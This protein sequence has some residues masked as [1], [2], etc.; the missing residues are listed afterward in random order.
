MRNIPRIVRKIGYCGS[1]LSGCRPVLQYNQ[2]R[3]DD[4][5]ISP[6]NIVSLAS[7]SRK[8]FLYYFLVQ[9]KWKESWIRRIKTLQNQRLNI[10]K[11]LLSSLQ[12]KKKRVKST[13]QIAIAQ[14]RFMADV[15]DVTMRSDV[16]LIC[17]LQAFMQCIEWFA[18]CFQPIK[19]ESNK[20]IS[21]SIKNLL[22][23]KSITS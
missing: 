19:C 10:W 8:P 17:V 18:I 2:E 4:F 12:W 21:S 15:D 23:V 9:W 13:I 7:L 22:P 14:H 1:S 11:I 6:M 20:L 5:D 16:L 3:F